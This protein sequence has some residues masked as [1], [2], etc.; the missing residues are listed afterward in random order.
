[1]LHGATVQDETV[2]LDAAGRA[3]VTFHNLEPGTNLVTAAAQVGG[4]TAFD[5]AAVTVIP[6][7]LTGGGSQSSTDVSIDIDH[8]RYHP[9]DRAGV[10]ASLAGAVG[11]AFVSVEGTRLFGAQTDDVHDGKIAT[12]VTVPEA[13][14]DISVGVA[15]VRDGAMY[16]ATRRLTVDGP[17]H[18]RLTALRAD[19]ATYAPGATATIAIDDGES[20]AGATIA[21]RLGDGLPSRGAA[22][23][24]APGILAAEGTTTQ[25]PDSDD[26]AWHTWVTPARSTAGDIFGEDRPHTAPP[27]ETAFAIA[28]PRTLVWNIE[29]SDHGDVKIVLPAVPGKYVLSILKV[30][31]DGDVG[32]ATLP[33]VVQ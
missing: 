22:F 8:T 2:K 9:G 32:A 33:L 31:D 10:T 30:T 26:P 19:R 4:D 15:F 11:Q 17:G 12:S 28:E 24:S 1:M 7:S 27:G 14:G 13:V 23:D 18:P 6:L 21:L 29:R 25:N 16:Y 20:H 3:S 5:A